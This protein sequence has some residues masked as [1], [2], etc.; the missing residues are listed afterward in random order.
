MLLPP[1]MS[2][3]LPALLMF[4]KSIFVIHVT[5]R[6]A[7]DG[8]FRPNVHRKKCCNRL[9]SQSLAMG[10]KSFLALSRTHVPCECAYRVQLLLCKR[11]CFCFCFL[12]LWRF[13]YYSYVGPFPDLCEVL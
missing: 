5:A 2:L 9:L 13:P 6:L 3:L 12:L 11:F 7:S 10:V 8:V 1:Q 4:F